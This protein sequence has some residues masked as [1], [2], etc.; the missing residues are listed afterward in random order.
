MGV[1]R[2]QRRWLQTKESQQR[3]CH[4]P[5]RQNK[6]KPRKPCGS[7]S[8]PI[9][10][11]FST[12]CRPADFQLCDENP[13]LISS[14]L[15]ECARAVAALFELEGSG[16]QLVVAEARRL[17]IESSKDPANSSPGF[18]D[19]EVVAIALAELDVCPFD[20][21]ETDIK[22]RRRKKRAVKVRKG[23]A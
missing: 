17:I 23:V 9:N 12:R 4:R 2:Q 5:S 3:L 11:D 21:D 19:S 10:L 16:W 15:I 22:P 13:D 18:I 1:W 6:T 20:D 8:G 7:A 14:Q